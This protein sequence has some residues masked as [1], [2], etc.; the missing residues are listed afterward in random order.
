MIDTNEA[1]ARIAVAEFEARRLKE[2][3]EERSR[4][5]RFAFTVSRILVA[6]GAAIYLQ[7]TH[8]QI[9]GTQACGFLFIYLAAS[10]WQEHRIGESHRRLQA[11][12]DRLK[13]EIESKSA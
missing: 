4:R 3:S 9:S 12:L 5:W 6:L 7:V 1:L 8:W 11:E 13:D 2:R 10:A